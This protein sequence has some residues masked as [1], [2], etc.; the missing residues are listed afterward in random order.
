MR[1]EAYLSFLILDIFEN[2]L[3]YSVNQ[4]ENLYKVQPKVN[5]NITFIFKTNKTFQADEVQNHQDN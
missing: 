4:S 1:Q 2:G 3:N 5:I